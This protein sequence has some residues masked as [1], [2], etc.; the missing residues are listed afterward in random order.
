LLLLVA[1]RVG[2]RHQKPAHPNR[3]PDKGSYPN[4]RRA[5]IK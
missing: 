5:T 2:E 4:K 1:S 3:P